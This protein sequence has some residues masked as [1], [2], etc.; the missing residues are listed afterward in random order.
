MFTPEER[1]H[2]RSDLL[3]RAACDCRIS[4]A[5]ITGS[6][7]TGREDRWSDID[8]ALGV[9][10]AAELPNCRMSSPIGLRECTISIRPCII[11]T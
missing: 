7:T 1:A 10:D 8:L 9:V 3:E 5:A 11:L 6:A 2:L 4:G